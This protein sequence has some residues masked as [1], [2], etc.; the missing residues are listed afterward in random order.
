MPRPV[1][2]HPNKDGSEPTSWF[3]VSDGKECGPV[4]VLELRNL[5]ADRS[6]KP[7]DL[8]WREGMDRWYEARWITELIAAP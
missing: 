6:V 8:V 3:Y 7:T 1:G 5:I 4:S 2:S